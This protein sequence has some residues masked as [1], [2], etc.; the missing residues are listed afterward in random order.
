MIVYDS[1]KESEADYVYDLIVR[2]FYEHVAPVYS[3]NGVDT[4]LSMISPTT[5][6]TANEGDSSF[7]IMARQDNQAISRRRLQPPAWPSPAESNR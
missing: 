4:F 2:V 6:I 5:L 7:V 1:M 3:D